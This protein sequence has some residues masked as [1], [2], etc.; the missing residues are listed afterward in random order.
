MIAAIQISHKGRDNFLFEKKTNN[1]VFVSWAHVSI[2]MFS[3]CY[4]L[5]SLYLSLSLSLSLISK[6]ELPVLK[7]DVNKSSK[8]WYSDAHFVSYHRSI[9]K[10]PSAQEKF[11]Y[12]CEHSLKHFLSSYFKAETQNRKTVKSRT[13]K[14]S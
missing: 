11:K 9:P 5:A 14:V 4:C 10:I 6:K 12:L 2:S 3:V 8:K 13:S 7:N 1:K